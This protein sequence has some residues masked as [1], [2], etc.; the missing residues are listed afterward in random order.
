MWEVNDELCVD[1][2][3]MTYEK[4]M[5]KGMNDE[6]VC[7]GLHMLLC[8]SEK[9]TMLLLSTRSKVCPILATHYLRGGTMKSTLLP[10]SSTPSPFHVCRGS[11]YLICTDCLLR[12]FIEVV[13]IATNAWNATVQYASCL[14]SKPL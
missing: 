2:A 14:R 10:L 11:R 5:D 12:L 13:E 8:L 6:S 1:M 4:L 9:N 3:R 7:L